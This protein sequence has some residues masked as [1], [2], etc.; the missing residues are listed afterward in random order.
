MYIYI[1]I[2]GE[3]IHKSNNTLLYKVR[4]VR[5]PKKHDVNAKYLPMLLFSINPNV[6]QVLLQLNITSGA[7]LRGLILYSTLGTA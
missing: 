1:Y 4:L 5:P 2:Y 7:F 6:N 3:L